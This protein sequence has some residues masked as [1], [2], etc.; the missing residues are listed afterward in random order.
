MFELLDIQTGFRAAL[1]V[2]KWR[3]IISK[4]NNVHKSLLT[5]LSVTFTVETKMEFVQKLLAS[6]PWNSIQAWVILF[7]TDLLSSTNSFYCVCYVI[8]IIY[9]QALPLQ[10][11]SVMTSDSGNQKLRKKIVIK[12]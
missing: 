5:T 2:N 7:V 11:T 8:L 4:R 3:N 9:V 10:E 1:L 12:V 6:D